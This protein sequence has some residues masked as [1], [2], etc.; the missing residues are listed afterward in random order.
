MGFYSQLPNGGGA[1]IRANS[2]KIANS[3]FYLIAFN[4]PLTD[5]AQ[6]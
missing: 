6:A 5:L 2:A 1:K 4:W 3:S